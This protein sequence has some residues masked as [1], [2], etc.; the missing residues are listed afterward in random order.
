MKKSTA[1]AS[2]VAFY[3]PAAGGGAMLDV[4]AGLGEPLNVSSRIYVTVT[5]E[6]CFRSLYLD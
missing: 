3:S 1:P 2:G 4:S 5:Y 6:N